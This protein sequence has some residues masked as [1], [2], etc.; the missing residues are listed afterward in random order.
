MKETHRS[1]KTSWLRA[2]M[3]GTN[4][5]IV[6]TSSLMIGI[7]AADASTHATIVAGIAGLAAGAMSMAI[8]EYISVSTQHDA[9][10]ADIALEKRELAT[11]P[12]AELRELAAI[13]VHRGLDKDL[14][15]KVAQQLSEHDRLGAHLKDELGIE[16]HTRARPVEAALTSMVTFAVS[17]ALPIVAFW[18]VPRIYTIAIVALVVLAVAGLL[19][20]YFG[21]AKRLVAAARVTVG[22]ALAMA[23]TA[24]VGHLAG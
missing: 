23:V 9:E 2:A 14:A 3:L 4:D 15:M 18:L 12:D 17:A 1:H 24:G 20:A 22:G 21:G 19:G 5:A 10:E 8:G 7:A 16:P 13:Y 6:S 11:M